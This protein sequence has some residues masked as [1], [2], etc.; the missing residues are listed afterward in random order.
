LPRIKPVSSNKFEKFLLK[1]GCTFV[2]QS[3]SH[4]VY[5]KEGL[6]RPIIVP[7]RKQITVGVIMSNLKTLKINREEYIKIIKKI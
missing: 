5:H 4:R 6:N 7:K 3:G 2:R 1:S